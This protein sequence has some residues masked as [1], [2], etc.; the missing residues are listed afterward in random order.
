V[1]HRDLLTTI[2]SSLILSLGSVL[3]YQRS[4]ALTLKEAKMHEENVDHIAD[5]LWR[6]VYETPFRGKSRGRFAITREQL[7]TA[8]GVHKLHRKT[9]RRLQDAALRKGLVIVD[10]DDV[11]PCVETRVVREYRR[12][13]KTIFESIFTSATEESEETSD[14]EELEEE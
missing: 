2:L 9:V 5:K 8:L 10:L 13:P 7:K 14:V 3:V 12:P 1:S 11:F 4:V 6:E